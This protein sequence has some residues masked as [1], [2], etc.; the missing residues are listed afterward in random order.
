L[1]KNTEWFKNARFGMFIHYGPYST[2]GRGEWVMA[3]E[4]WTIDEY[5]MI[6]QSM[7]TDPANIE[8]S[9]SLARRAGMKYAVFTTKHH[10]G[11]CQWESEVSSY[12]S[13]KMGPQLDLVKI[14]VN[15]CRKEGLRVGLYYSLADWHHPDGAMCA[16]DENARKR[17]LTYTSG[18]IR[19]LLT[20]YGHIDLLWFDGPWPLGK[21]ENWD[22]RKIESLIRELQPQILINDRLG[23]GFAGDFS[24]S[25]RSIH[26]SEGLW[27]ACM[28]MNDDWGYASRL[29]EDWV[30]VKDIAMMLRKCS[31]H[32]G[33]LLL[34]VGP[35]GN[36]ALPALARERLEK[37]GAWLKLHGEALYPQTTKP[38][39]LPFI[40]NTGYWSAAGN[41][42]YYW[43]SRVWPGKE[44]CLGGLEGDIEAV[45]ILGSAIPLTWEKL[46]TRVI[47]GGLPET[48]PERAAHV[49][50]LKITFSHGFKQVFPYPHQEF[51]WED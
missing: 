10:D 23:A 25:E 44:L 18:C 26:A 12:N 46:N 40:S 17:F 32:G 37:I 7:E 5:E 51:I 29:E 48:N 22:S 38:A 19:E 8:E 45:E 42:A 47:I 34:N 49:P 24:T 1:T 16:T 20:N 9:V 35:Q 3:Q 39:E 11:F 43:L 50:I 14:F 36:G 31:I 15:A 41:V 4:G 30:S 2:I 13:V 6:V 27:E 33:N 28:T 21:S